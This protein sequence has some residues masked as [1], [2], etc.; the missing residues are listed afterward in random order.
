MV[1]IRDFFKDLKTQTF[2]WLFILAYSGALNVIL[3]P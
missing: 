3:E 1:S 2:D